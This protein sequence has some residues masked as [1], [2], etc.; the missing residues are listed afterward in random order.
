MAAPLA[1]LLEALADEAAA[2]PGPAMTALGPVLRQARE[3]LDRDLRAWVAAGKGGMRFTPQAYRSMLLQIGASEEAIRAAGQAVNR[4]LTLHGAI[5]RRLA[6]S[7]TARELGAFEPELGPSVPVR[8]AATLATGRAS[9]LERYSRLAG[10]YSDEVLRDLHRELAV[11]VLRGETNDQLLDRLMRLG[12]A[13]DRTGLLG[14]AWIARAEYRAERIV[15]T[16]LA[17]AY[18]TEI[19]DIYTDLRHDF[20]DLQRRWDAHADGRLCARCQTLHGRTIDPSKGETFDGVEGP[21]LHPNCRCRAG[22]WRPSWAAHLEGHAPPAP[23]PAPSPPPRRGTLPPPRPPRPRRATLPPPPRPVLAPPL[24]PPARIGP[25][26]PPTFAK[27]NAAQAWASATYPGITWDL[28]GMHV[29]VLNEL[30]PEFHRLATEW[31]EVANR[32]RYFGTYRTVKHPMGSRFRWGT[33]TYAHASTDGARIAFNP[34]WF[35]KPAR[36]RAQLLGDAL[37]GWHPEGTGAV[38]SVLTHEWGHQVDN[39]LRRLAGRSLTRH[40]PPGQVLTVAQALATMRARTPVTAALSRYG[41]K[42][43]E[44]AFAEA[45]ASLRYTNPTMHT[46]Y[47][48][49][50]GRLLEMARG[51]H[52]DAASMS[53]WGSA[54]AAEQSVALARLAEIRDALWP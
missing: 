11:G 25:A 30:L 33:N 1:N 15:R 37:S 7:H 26:G 48:R 23:E 3:E 19:G 4:T 32:L 49:R 17:A 20:P 50:L 22:L 29:D 46:E 14:G 53:A 9:P 28:A 52:Y 41:L 5:A 8:L 47:T 13:A 35:G 16:E 31:P 43:A 36:I 42:N 27:V 24:P 38:A 45:F 54:S 6:L 44:E 39:Y 12:R 51:P 21:P 40:A 34:A 2:L 10:R 18:D